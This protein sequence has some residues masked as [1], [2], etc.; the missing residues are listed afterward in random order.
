MKFGRKFFGHDF[1]FFIDLPM[2]KTE[3]VSFGKN[4]L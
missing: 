4:K 3:K 2:I 1:I